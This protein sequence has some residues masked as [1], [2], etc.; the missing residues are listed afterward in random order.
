MHL[1][2]QSG[3]GRLNT[4]KLMSLS[5]NCPAVSSCAPSSFESR[6]MLL[7]G[8]HQE[9]HAVAH[10]Q[11]LPMFLGELPPDELKAGGCWSIVV[12]I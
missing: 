3:D 1:V 6:C 2:G 5:Q 10:S 8:G 9:V 4:P 11:R 7:G 12:V